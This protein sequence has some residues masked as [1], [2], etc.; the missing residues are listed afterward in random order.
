VYAVDG[1]DSDPATATVKLKPAVTLTAADAS[2]PNPLRLTATG[3]P[4]GGEYR[5]TITG[6]VPVP[7]P[8]NTPTVTLTE[9]GEYSVKVVYVVR[10]I[11]S[12]PAQTTVRLR[13]TVTLTANPPEAEYPSEITLTAEGNP[14]GGEY[15]WQITTS[16]GLVVNGDG[17]TVPFD[18][19]GHYTARVIYKFR[20]VES[21][22]ATANALLRPTVSLRVEPAA[23]VYPDVVTATSSGNPEGG[24]YKWKIQTPNG[25]IG[26]SGPVVTL[27]EPGRY[28]I[29][30]VY[31]KN[32]AESRPAT[33]GALIRPTVTLTA[34]PAEAAVPEV[35]TLLAA[36]APPGGT[37][38]WMING[39]AVQDP[40]NGPVARLTNPGRYQATVVY[41]LNGAESDP[42]SV[43]V[44]IRPGGG[45]DENGRPN[46]GEAEVD[47]EQTAEVYALLDAEEP[48]SLTITHRIVTINTP[49]ERD[50]H[51]KLRLK[52]K[53]GDP[54]IADLVLDG[55]PYT[56][57][58]Q[59][60]V[61]EP[62]H[63]GGGV[64]DWH[65]GS[66]ALSIYGK[67]VG[68]LVV[69]AEVDPD[70][71]VPE[72][73]GRPFKNAEITINVF[74]MEAKSGYSVG[75]LRKVTP[76]LTRDRDGKPIFLAFAERLDDKHPAHVLLKIDAWPR[77]LNELRSGRLVIYDEV[78][79][80][81]CADLE[82]GIQG[83]SEFLALVA[84]LRAYWALTPEWLRPYVYPFGSPTVHSVYVWVLATSGVSQADAKY[85]WQTPEYK[86]PE[87]KRLIVAKAV[88]EAG[89]SR[90][91]RLAVTNVVADTNRDGVVNADD[92][93]DAKRYAVDYLQPMGT[94]VL[95]N[96]NF[97]GKLDGGRK[98]DCDD[99]QVNGAADLDDVGV[100]KLHKLG[101]TADEIPGDMTVKLQLL[102]PDRDTTGLAAA[103]KAHVF[104]GRQNNSTV[105]LGGT[106]PVSVV[107]KK[108]PGAGERNISDLA[109]AG[110]L[111]L[112]IEGVEYGTEVIV[113]LTVSI[114]IQKLLEDSQHILVSPFLVAS[115]V[116]ELRQAFVGTSSH[117]DDADTAAF[118]AAFTALCNT[119]V[120]PIDAAS[121][122][123]NN[124]R[125]VWVQDC[126]EIGYV[127]MAARSQKGFRE[128]NAVLDLSR[129]QGLGRLPSEL[130]T[131]AYAQYN[132]NMGYVKVINRV[133]ND[134]EAWQNGGGNIE[135]S[136]AIPDSAWPAGRVLVGG[137]RN[138]NG[139]VSPQ[140]HEELRKFLERQKVQVSS[141]SGILALDT[142]WLAVGHVDEIVSFVSIN[143]NNRILV[144]AP[145][146][147]MQQWMQAGGD[148][149]VFA[150]MT[151]RR[152]LK[153]KFQVTDAELARIPD[154]TL[155]QTVKEYNDSLWN[156]HLKFVNDALPTQV[157]MTAANVIL[158]PV[159]FLPNPNENGR[160]S[161]LVTGNRVNLFVRGRTQFILGDNPAEFADDPTKPVIMRR[162][163]NIPPNFFIDSAFIYGS[164]GD[165]HCVSNAIRSGPERKEWMR[166]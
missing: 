102:N 121:Y 93:V 52:Y 16:S 159:V 28:T 117:A 21:L 147:A 83:D 38:R 61:V 126:M 133:L 124:V 113:K 97:D 86:A 103:Q 12:D 20:N 149:S 48:A 104:D 32:G 36:G 70:P 145:H 155:A 47:G 73:D 122:V 9:V 26:G 40:G 92:V 56:L 10:G 15:V 151:V 76:A 7:D 108:T 68:T 25:E 50:L 79:Q 129:P 45:S 157:A 141:S 29:E 110:N 162:L 107:Y 91:V 27:T 158:I 136:P 3:N 148:Y 43:T 139:T 37:Y 57:G 140:I 144:A 77:L 5:W 98:R 75:S 89:Q 58:T 134:D 6:P 59:I 116:C 65:S 120:I 18:Q 30:V 164:A 85:Y 14:A 156:N 109:G 23:A 41:E 105:M 49:R 131:A 72:G 135:A 81:K 160:A 46:R 150:T 71:E 67:K 94:L 17:P 127:R 69:E 118:A 31:E 123:A 95:A 115:N 35:I 146:E 165:V 64:H 161:A 53:S 13:P 60:P 34:N 154:A 1:I 130:S 166:P 137:R 4:P 51:G 128:M 125:D 163:G 2:F 153:D 99:E 96:T 132:L 90:R 111:E 19:P 74:R 88:G 84:L 42:A 54:S 55:Q 33:G 80:E 82:R 100:V 114:G 8:G 62:G 152:C 112:G 142:S 66:V 119:P 39:P 106:K 101:L 44:R 24:I 78:T 138:A 63:E 87:I 11:Q 22:P 143:G